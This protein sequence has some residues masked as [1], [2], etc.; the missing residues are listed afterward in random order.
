MAFSGK[1]PD[2]QRKAAFGKG[3]KRLKY[4]PKFP[5]GFCEG[6]GKLHKQDLYVARNKAL[7]YDKL[8]PEEKATVDE[9][10]RV[11]GLK[12]DAAKCFDEKKK[13]F[14]LVG[15]AYAAGKKSVSPRAGWGSVPL[16]EVL[17][18]KQLKAITDLF[19]SGEGVVS[20]KE[21]LAIV[22]SDDSKY[23]GK[24]LP[25]YLAYAVEFTLGK[26][27]VKLPSETLPPQLDSGVS[28][29]SEVGG[30]DFVGGMAMQRVMADWLG[31]PDLLPK[32]E[33]EG[34]KR[35]F[36]AFIKAKD[37]F[38][39]KVKEVG[40]VPKEVER[41]LDV[42]QLRRKP[43]VLPVRS[44]GDIK[45][46]EAA[47]QSLVKSF[48]QNRINLVHGEG[49]EGIWAV[50]CS[51]EDKKLW[52]DNSSK[53]QIINVRLLNQPLG[54][55]T[56]QW[57]DVVRVRTNG[58]ER[59][60]AFLNDNKDSLSPLADFHP[61][62]YSEYEL[63]SIVRGVGMRGCEAFDYSTRGRPVLAEDAAVAEAE[64]RRRRLV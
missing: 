14:D 57:G 52:Y 32:S 33:D 49:N 34:T 25:E 45:K 28:P 37:I 60:T 27:A 51:E 53:G 18:S 62:N 54:W 3:M 20:H 61:E 43:I 16:G 5:P 26:K 38:N 31:R 56:K 42:A 4:S 50:P 1:N 64:L 22:E 21:V 46:V 8:R 48:G 19:N 63:K 9:F 55:G 24:L 39:A 36:E 30:F 13:T 11:R 40:G 23:V 7:C 47:V 58:K 59:P 44:A 6:C 35:G 10:L 2:E 12:A 15:R 29:R 41:D 17:T